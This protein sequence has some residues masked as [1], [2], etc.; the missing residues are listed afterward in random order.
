M[1]TQL[2]F[3]RAFSCCARRTA[4][5]AQPVPSVSLPAEK[6]APFYAFVK[7]ENLTVLN[8]KRT[9]REIQ[10]LLTPQLLTRG[11]RYPEVAGL[12]TDRS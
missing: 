10:I 4:L 6:R 9:E 8:A 2:D 11:Y 3:A 7:F 5:L 12:S 1:R